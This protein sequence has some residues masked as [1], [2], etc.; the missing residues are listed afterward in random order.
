MVITSSGKSG[1]QVRKASTV[2]PVSYL[3]CK[4][5]AQTEHIWQKCQYFTKLGDVHTCFFLRTFKYTQNILQKH[6][7]KIN[8][9]LLTLFRFDLTANFLLSH[10][11]GEHRCCLNI[12]LS[13]VNSF[14]WECPRTKRP[15][16]TMSISSIVPS[17]K[18]TLK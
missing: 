18:G 8:L 16:Q 4:R 15:Y 10:L 11:A 12:F 6:K 14:F 5:M 3:F 7:C 9:P 17:L 13:I 1:E 2:S